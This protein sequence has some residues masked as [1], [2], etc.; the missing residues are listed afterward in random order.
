[1][2]MSS[3]SAWPLLRLP[4]LRWLLAYR[5]GAMLSYQIVAVAVG[6]QL[7]QRTGDPLALGLAGL[8]EVLP[9]FCVAPFAGQCARR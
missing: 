9:Y 7:Y 2:S 6:W 1:M 8:A 3:S 4:G 5:I